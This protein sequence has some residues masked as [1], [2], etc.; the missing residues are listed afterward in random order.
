[1]FCSDEHTFSMPS[2]L[3]GGLLLVLYI[4]C[5][6]LFRI[7]ASLSC[8]SPCAVPTEFTRAAKTCWPHSLH[9]PPDPDSTILCARCSSWLIVGY[10]ISASPHLNFSIPTP[11]QTM[12]LPPADPNHPSPTWM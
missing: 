3:I 9:P 2:T 1:M 7:L 11:L 8:M 6:F 10:F 12:N 5:F 4:I